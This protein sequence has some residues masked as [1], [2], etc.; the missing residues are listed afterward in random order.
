MLREF[1]PF[2]ASK[3]PMVLVPLVVAWVMVRALLTVTLAVP[4]S[5]KLLNEVA[6]V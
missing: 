2:T 4:P 3:P 1:S 6:V 5:V